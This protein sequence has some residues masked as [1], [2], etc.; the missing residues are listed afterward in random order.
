MAHRPFFVHV[1]DLHLRPDY[2][3]CWPMLDVFVKQINTMNPA[4]DFVM[5]TGDIIFG[6]MRQTTDPADAERD[7][8]HYADIMSGI[9]VPV[10]HAVGNHDMVLD[11]RPVSTGPC[12]KTL[13]EKYCGKR[14][15][16]F[17]WGR[18]HCV[19]LD[20]WLI[21]PFED[22]IRV[23]HD[24][25]DEQITWLADDLSTCPD[26]TEV[27]LFCHHHLQNP[28]H[29]DFWNRL[30]TTAL[31]DRLRYTEIIGCDHMNS[32]W[33][34]GNFTSHA[35]VSLC[36]AWWLTAAPDGT[37]GGYAL[38][39]DDP[40]QGLKPYYKPNTAPL[41]V[42]SPRHGQIVDDTVTVD[43]YN[44]FNG[45]FAQKQLDIDNTRPGCRDIPVSSDQ[46]V[47]VFVRP[48]A[49]QPA[50]AATDVRCRFLLSETDESPLT[51]T[52]NNAA[53]VTV[54]TV[55]K[56]GESLEVPLP[57]DHLRQWNTVTFS[58]TAAVKSPELMIDGRT[59]ADP[60]VELLEANRPQWFESMDGLKLLWEFTGKGKP[61]P[62]RMP[63][64]TFYY[65][66]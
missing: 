23:H 30:K 63:R 12:C 43:T 58:G 35:T 10:Y 48:T 7:Y 15:W 33:Q 25:D 54:P 52:F 28:I 18:Y 50:V 20:Q 34:Q 27:L 5:V 56:A 2:I 51:I 59:V 47:T 29:M 57:A 8:R 39:F 62:F 46:N 1:T 32:F 19:I 65:P 53:P 41:A 26:D 44:P 64:D 17:D 66:A 4:P 11:D 45:T 36:G 31:P 55:G 14:Y 49:N 60:L 42:T 37:P 38:F 22:G 61:T 9:S 13:F 24:M 16:S 40:D 6:N 3:N 21:K